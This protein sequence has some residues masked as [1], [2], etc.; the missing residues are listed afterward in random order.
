[1]ANDALRARGRDESLRQDNGDSKPII[2]IPALDLRVEVGATSIVLLHNLPFVNQRCLLV[3]K[4][5][6]FRGRRSACR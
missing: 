1:M 5:L 3:A 6:L 4:V 2:E